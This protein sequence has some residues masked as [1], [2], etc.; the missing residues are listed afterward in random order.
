MAT[1]RS[2]FDLIKERL[3]MHDVA[4]RYGYQPNRAGFISCPFHIA[5]NTPSLKI[6]K[7]IGRGFNCFACGASGSVI[8]F[9]MLLFKIDFRQAVVRINADFGLGL[10]DKKPDRRAHAKWL[11]ERAEQEQIKAKKTAKQRAMV[12]KHRALWLKICESPPPKTEA[13]AEQRAQ[14]LARLQHLRHW[15]DVNP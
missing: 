3:S 7:D 14:D 2:N 8:D 11:K 1:Y 5:D 12:D 13:E 6:Y 15:L 10:T 4:V 9:V